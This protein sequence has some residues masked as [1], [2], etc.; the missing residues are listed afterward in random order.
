MVMYWAVLDP[1][2]THLHDNGIAIFCLDVRP[3]IALE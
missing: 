2:Q 3:V 1:I